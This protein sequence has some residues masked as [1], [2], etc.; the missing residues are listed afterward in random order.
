MPWVRALD[1]GF[2]ENEGPTQKRD[3]VISLSVVVMNYPDNSQPSAGGLQ[4]SDVYLQ[5]YV[6]RM[7][8]LV[9]PLQQEA[10]LA[11]ASPLDFAACNIQPGD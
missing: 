9:K 8:L 7:L 5:P 1:I 10:Q 11:Q 4:V 3:S 6:A 2:G